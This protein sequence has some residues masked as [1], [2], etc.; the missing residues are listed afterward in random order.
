MPRLIAFIGLVVIGVA[1]ALFLISERSAITG[2]GYRVARLEAE[3]RRLVEANRKLEAQIAV[4]KTP[5]AIE[6][7]V[8]GLQLDLVSPEESLDQALA[9]QKADEKAKAGGDAPARTR[10]GR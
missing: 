10:K 4:A 8:K 1:A 3:R 7:R 2:V 5:A 6:A 9:K